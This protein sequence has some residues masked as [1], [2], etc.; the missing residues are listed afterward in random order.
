MVPPQDAVLAW[1]YL[2]ILVAEGVDAAEAL[3][4][5]SGSDIVHAKNYKNFKRP[6]GRAP[7][8]KL[9]EFWR[10]GTTAA[11]IAE[12]GAQRLAHGL[13]GENRLEPIPY[14]RA[15]FSFLLFLRTSD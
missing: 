14:F 5:G 15:A 12:H 10:K 1:P 8:R 6:R 11:G 13:D 7:P 2:S 9:D 4:N 3:C